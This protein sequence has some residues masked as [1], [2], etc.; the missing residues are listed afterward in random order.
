MTA[1]EQRLAGLRRGNAVRTAK[2]RYKDRIRA[3]E[4]DPA[5][6]IL[7]CD[8]GITVEQLLR[9]TPGVGG[10]RVARIAASAGVGMC[11]RFDAI[12]EAERRALA[13]ALGRC[14]PRPRPPGVALD[15]GGSRNC[16]RCGRWRKIASDFAVDY[17]SKVARPWVHRICRRCE[18]ATRRRPVTVESDTR[19]CIKCEVTKPIE[20][21]SLRNAGHGVMT[22]AKTC[23]LCLATSA[24]TK[25][26]AKAAAKLAPLRA[27]PCACPPPVQVSP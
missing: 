7:T 23:Q 13:D 2:A 1:A 22:R 20:A 11:R 4:L 27:A 3:G 9:A 10:T 16:S 21:F 19:R 24:E 26:E 25:R 17:H 15:V 14:A 12:S 6:A 8:L 18:S 5:D